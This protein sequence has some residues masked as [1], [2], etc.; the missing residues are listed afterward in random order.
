M[1]SE[2]GANILESN[3]LAM[4]SSTPGGFTSGFIIMQ[5]Y[6]LRILLPPAYGILS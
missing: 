2:A 6:H 1:N 3:S 5:G 4:F